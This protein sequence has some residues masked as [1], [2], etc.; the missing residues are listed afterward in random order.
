MAMTT[1][2]IPLQR[3]PICLNNNNSDLCKFAYQI[4]VCRADCL[5]L[6]ILSDA[7]RPSLSSVII[8]S[9]FLFKT[10]HN[11]LASFTYCHCHRGDGTPGTRCSVTVRTLR[12]VMLIVREHSPFSVVLPRRLVHFRTGYLCMFPAMY[13]NANY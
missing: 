1:I 4:S 7:R 5:C 6:L 2:D 13:P 3:R 8:L 11:G 10:G 12:Y 9:D